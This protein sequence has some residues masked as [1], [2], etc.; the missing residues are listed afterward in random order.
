MVSKRRSPGRTQERT[1][2]GKE[3]DRAVEI[4]QAQTYIDYYLKE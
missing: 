2:K 4:E 3:R 1:G